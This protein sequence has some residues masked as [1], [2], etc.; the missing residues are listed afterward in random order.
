MTRWLC[1]AIALLTASMLS[2]PAGAADY[3][4]RR[5][6]VVT[7]QSWVKAA[8]P[9]PFPRSPRAQAVWAEGGCWKMCQID[10]TDGLDRGVEA[11]GDQ[12]A[13]LAATNLCDRSCQQT[14]RLAGGPLLPPIPQ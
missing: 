8:R 13:A 10:C 3:S 7:Q 5:D 9:L 11:D 14:C 2:L 1:V 4:L 12:V 6:R